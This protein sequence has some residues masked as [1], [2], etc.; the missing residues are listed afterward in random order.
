M[1]ELETLKAQRKTI[2]AT[3]TRFMN[4]F[5]DY[6]QSSGLGIWRTTLE[7]LEPY[8]DKYKGIQTQIEMSVLKNTN[9]VQAE[10]V[11]R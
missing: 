3:I 10:E 2:E 11:E 4:A 1:A 9:A 7:K 8:F 6:D 5:K